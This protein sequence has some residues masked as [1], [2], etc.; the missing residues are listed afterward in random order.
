MAALTAYNWPGNIGAARIL[1]EHSGGAAA[2]CAERLCLTSFG[3][4]SGHLSVDDTAGESHGGGSG[5]R[6]TV[7]KAEFLG[8]G[9]R[10]GAKQ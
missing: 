5:W 9:E 10:A 6:K 1:T 2:C 8:W 3:P 4:C 7:I